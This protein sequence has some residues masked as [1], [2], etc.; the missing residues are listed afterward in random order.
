MLYEDDSDKF[1]NA[2]YSDN[3][4]SETSPYLDDRCN[5]FLYKIVLE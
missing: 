5:K 3:G 4:L 2:F 1:T